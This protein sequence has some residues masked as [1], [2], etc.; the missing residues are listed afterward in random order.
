MNNSRALIVIGSI[1]IFFIALV[2]K[3][4]DIQILHAEEYTYN[5]Q[6]QQ[7]GVEKISAERGLIFDRN[8]VL[9]VYNRTDVSFFADL[10]MLKQSDRKEI[11]KLFAK[12]FNKSSNYYLNL[13]KGSKKTICIEKKAPGDLAASLK[14]KKRPGFFYKEEPTRVYHYN[15]LASHI[16][17]YI[18][19]EDEGVMGVSEFYEDALNGEDGSRLIHKNALGEIVT[20]DDEAVSYTHF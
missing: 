6:R 19:N 18:N 13:M 2:V 7:T 20:V 1:L 9:L 10:R 15:N 16:L 5:A 17:G 3:L 8:N 12:K 14:N 4:V 11:A